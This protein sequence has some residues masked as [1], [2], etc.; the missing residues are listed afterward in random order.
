MGARSRHTATTLPN[1]TMNPTISGW[2]AFAASTASGVLGWLFRSTHTRVSELEREL[3]AFKL[4][5]AETYVTSTALE[6]SIDSLNDTIQAVF[7]KLD[8]IED[9][10]DGK[11]DKK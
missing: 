6:R 1:D 8:R 11:A 10:L 9:K 5:C 4:H 3:A 2:L 7:S